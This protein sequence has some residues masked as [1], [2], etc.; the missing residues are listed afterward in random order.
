[1]EAWSSTGGRSHCRRWKISVGLE[2]RWRSVVGNSSFII[3]E[4]EARPHRRE[5]IAIAMVMF[6]VERMPGSQRRLDKGWVEQSTVGAAGVGRDDD[7]ENAKTRK[8]P[9]SKHR[10]LAFWTKWS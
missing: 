9:L 8:W 1:M 4:A 7:D 5:A 6:D 10:R 2:A 3:T